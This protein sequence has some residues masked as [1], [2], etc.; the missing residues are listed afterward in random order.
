[1]SLRKAMLVLA[2][3]MVAVAIAVPAASAATRTAATAAPAAKTAPAARQAVLP[4]FGICGLLTAQRAIFATNPILVAL[5][6]RTLTIL[7][8]ATTMTTASRV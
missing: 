3:V 4:G 5:L 8:C 7:G 2:A 1:M 6:T